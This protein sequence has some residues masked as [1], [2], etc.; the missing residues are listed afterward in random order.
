MHV[1]T[2]VIMKAMKLNKVKK[3]MMMLIKKGMSITTAN[4]DKQQSNNNGER[5]LDSQEKE[6]IWNDVIK[7]KDPDVY[8]A[9][10][11][12]VYRTIILR[13][14]SI[15]VTVVKKTN[16]GGIGQGKC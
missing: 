15:S 14:M 11:R 9:W 16:F 10:V 2:K 13:L 3:S 12:I 1:I 7:E 8:L 4:N 6:R 5:S